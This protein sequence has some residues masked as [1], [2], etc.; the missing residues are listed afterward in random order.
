MPFTTVR[1]VDKLCAALL[2]LSV[3]S[4]VDHLAHSYRLFCRPQKKSKGSNCTRAPLLVPL[5]DCVQAAIIRRP[6]VGCLPFVEFF[7]LVHDAVR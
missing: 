1:A 4:E 5:P 7:E 3:R 6:M 2:F